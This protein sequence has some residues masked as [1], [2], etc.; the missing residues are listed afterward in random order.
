MKKHWVLP[1]PAYTHYVC[2]PEMLGHYSDFPQHA[3][4]RSEGLLNSYNLHM[5]FGGEGY[6]FQEGER[7]SMKRGSGFLFPRGAYQ[8][9]GSEPGQAWN[10]RWVHFATALSLPMLEEADHSRG[11]FF[12]FDPGTGYEPVFEE[13]YRLSA[14]YETRS[15]P[16]LSTLL[17]EILVTLM[18]NSEP[19]HGRCRWRSDI[20]SGSRPTGYTANASG[21]GHW[22]RWLGLPVTAAIIFCGCSGA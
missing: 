19:L 20:P 13:M 11:Y 18:Q 15:E 22:K 14:A 7:I 10:V 9:Y 1:Q 2:Y 5:V 6:V 21:P 12:T 3:E 8:Q 17:Y 16:R 4:R